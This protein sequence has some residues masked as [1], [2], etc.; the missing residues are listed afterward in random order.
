MIGIKNQCLLWMEILKSRVETGEP[1]IMFE[2]NVN[3][4]NPMAYHNEQS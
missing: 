2:D 1:Y 4:D 3:K